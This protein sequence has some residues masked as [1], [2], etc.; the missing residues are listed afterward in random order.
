MKLIL[1]TAAA[2]ISMSNAFAASAPAPQANQ[3]M[4]ELC[5]LSGTLAYVAAIGRDSGMTQKQTSARIM[6]I[7]GK[8]GL[9]R[10]R[11]TRVTEIIYGP[12]QNYTPDAARGFAFNA[13][14]SHAAHLPL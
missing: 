12:L 4:G 10:E 1:I 11:V 7:A 2:V 14:F 13:C 6:Q 5:K 3:E 9:E 8:Y